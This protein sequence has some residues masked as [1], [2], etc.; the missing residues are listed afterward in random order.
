[1]ALSA[2]SIG[3]NAR[4]LRRVNDAS[5]T[6]LRAK[7]ITL[8]TTQKHKREKISVR[9]YCFYCCAP[10]LSALLELTQPTSRNSNYGLQLDC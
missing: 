9:S 3:C 10:V 7:L 5:I 1:M 2:L 6:D 4:L 8:V